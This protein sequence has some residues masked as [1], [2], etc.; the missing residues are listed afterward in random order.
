M[1]ISS[2]SPAT[3]PARR[4]RVLALGPLRLMCD[5]E[6]I[7]L[8]VPPV[9]RSGMMGRQS[10]EGRPLLG[11]LAC[12][13]PGVKL[14]CQEVARKLW[15]NLTEKNEWRKALN[16]AL[17][18][19]RDYMRES[20]ADISPKEFVQRTR[21][22]IWLQSWVTTD[23]QDFEAASSAEEAISHYAGALLSEFEASEKTNK[24]LFDRRVA[25]ENRFKKWSEE[26]NSSGN[27]ALGETQ[28]LSLT[29]STWPQSHARLIEERLAERLRI[30][31]PQLR[32]EPEEVLHRFFDHEGVHGFWP[33]WITQWSADGTADDRPITLPDLIASSHPCLLLVSQGG[34]GK[35]S[36][37]GKLF[38]DAA[39]GKLL[40]EGQPWT[41]LLLPLQ[42]LN[43][44]NDRLS[45]LEK[46]LLDQFLPDHPASWQASSLWK[47]LGGTANL[48][49]LLEGLNEVNDAVRDNATQLVSNIETMVGGLETSGINYRVV[50]SV[51][52]QEE[53]Q[54]EG[55]MRQLRASEWG[56]HF[57]AYR[58]EPL[59]WNEAVDKLNDVLGADAEQFIQL[60]GEGSHA[61]LTN[62]L[63]LRL[64]LDNAVALNEKARRGEAPVITRSGLYNI[65]VER[66][67]ERD[68]NERRLLGVLQNASMARQGLEILAAASLEGQQ[69]DNPTAHQS[70][71]RGGGT[72]LT[73]EAVPYLLERSVREKKWEAANWWRDLESR[74]GRRLTYAEVADA[75]LRLNLVDAPLG[76]HV[77][78]LHE[79]FRDYLA[80]GRF[81][82]SDDTYGRDSWRQD[83]AFENFQ[84]HKWEGTIGFA[85][86]R[87]GSAEPMLR[88]AESELLP[89]ETRRRAL[90]LWRL[91]I[92]PS[93][94]DI[95]RV[96][97][98][99]TTTGERLLLDAVGHALQDILLQPGTEKARE[100]FGIRLE[101]LLD[102]DEATHKIVAAKIV[103]V[104]GHAAGPQVFKVMLR[105]LDDHSSGVRVAAMLSFVANEIDDNSL[106]EVARLCLDDG[107]TMVRFV[108][109]DVLLA[110]F[111]RKRD[112][113]FRHMVQSVVGEFRALYRAPADRF[114]VVRWLGCSSLEAWT[115]QVLW[116]ELT[117]VGP[118]NDEETQVVRWMAA[119]FLCSHLH[120]AK[121]TPAQKE[122]LRGMAGDENEP[123][124]LR[125]VLDEL[126][127]LCR[128]FD[129]GESSWPPSETMVS[130]DSS[131]DLW[132]LFDA[133]R[134][135]EPLL[136]QK[137]QQLQHSL[138]ATYHHFLDSA[139]ENV[140]LA[141]SYFSLSPREQQALI[142]HLEAT[143]KRSN[144]ESQ[145][146][147][148]RL[149]CCL[150][151]SDN[152]LLRL[153][154]LCLQHPDADVRHHAATSVMNFVEHSSLAH[155]L[156]KNLHNDLDHAARWDA[157]G[158]LCHLVGELVLPDLIDRARNDSSPLVRGFLAERLPSFA[159]REDAREALRFSLE[160]EP[161]ALA[162]ARAIRAYELVGTPDGLPLLQSLFEDTRNTRHGAIDTLARRAY[163]V[164]ADNPEPIWA[165]QPR[166]FRATPHHGK[167]T[168]ALSTG[169]LVHKSRL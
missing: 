1:P 34:G 35:S 18:A 86:E 129:D 113:K 99:F 6:E 69:P 140:R 167:Q 46:V 154:L 20:P 28:D 65:A 45:S 123:P 53:A 107:D 31:L 61:V 41:P 50:I 168:A 36:N 145:A 62:P 163:R 48:L 134:T 161:N 63:L 37:L 126:E 111:R 79:T 155:R 104:L 39:R 60:L 73:R 169:L 149:L 74:S 10:K 160:N 114:S 43:V 26:A 159:H 29:A 117:D 88:A 71:R 40:H 132:G 85:V 25:L 91:T 96:W 56:R 151:V 70:E 12:Y 157:A 76:T 22:Q 13:K 54:P 77:A 100:S 97:G 95:K 2:A 27:Q 122:T 68:S 108:A 147:A 116:E 109:L 133:Q 119:R 144:R 8:S 17:L 130:T 90:E 11:L 106:A 82:Q 58:L 135:E 136:W 115:T 23:V 127:K 24:W 158:S 52:Q 128:L 9:K 112:P 125:T 72:Y 3:P 121:L 120:R 30:Y 57:V 38:F 87:T 14:K 131:V 138:D 5:D 142:S 94:E 47:E 66:L 139:W 141:Y 137:W 64:M 67:L 59:S 98:I 78:F 101:D 7:P 51:R 19:L 153:R 92:I 21:D 166:E 33:Q 105:A 4:Y 148:V 165:L 118:Y 93:L 143:L 32:G 42:A 150:G 16:D 80:S 110:A 15:P 164:I 152:S 44:L 55:L 75:L 103:R 146:S 83:V 156:W 162:C 81:C 84:E 89:S 49:V 124:P 102:E